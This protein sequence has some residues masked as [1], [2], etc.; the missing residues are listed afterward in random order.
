MMSLEQI[1]GQMQAGTATPGEL[2]HTLTILSGKYAYASNQ[3]E[4]ILMVKPKAWNDIRPNY[5]SDTACDRAW[6][7]TDDGLKEMHWRMALKK[8]E[9]MMAA[10]KKLI[11]VKTAEAYN[12]M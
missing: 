9:K 4:Q 8:I 5:K 11:D 6:E 10:I 3:L 7:G 2:A 1:E 12:Q